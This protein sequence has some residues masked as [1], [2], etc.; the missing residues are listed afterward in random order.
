MKKEIFR[1]YI[2]DKYD[3]WLIW[4]EERRSRNYLRNLSLNLNRDFSK[5]IGKE[6]KTI[7]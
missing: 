6:S 2:F 7:F 4:R 3:D 5:L 1:S